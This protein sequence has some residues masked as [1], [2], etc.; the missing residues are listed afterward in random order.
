MNKIGLQDAVGAI[1]CHDITKIVPGEF[2]GRAFKKGHIITKEDM[3]ELLKLG[4][5]HIYVWQAQEG[6]VHENEAAE[7]L[8]R[9]VRG[10][11]LT[12]TEPNEG[13][14]NLVVQHDGMLEINEGLLVE[15]NMIE[16]IIVATRNNQRVVKKGDVVAGVRVIPLTI[17]ESKLQLVRDI[18]V[19]GGIVNVTP[20]K[21]LKVGIVTTGSEVFH[22]RIKDKFGPVITEKMA[23]YNCEV[24]EQIIVPDDPDR[25]SAAIKKLIANGAELIT[26]T[27]GMSVDPD[28]VTPSG[29]RNAGAQIITHGAPVLPG[30]MLLVAYL[31]DIPVL[32]LPGCVMYSKT[33]IF[34]LLIPL[35]LSGKK[36]TR[37]MVAKLGL[38]GLCMECEV[39]QFPVCPFGTGS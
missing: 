25:I 31:G 20:L 14:I 38:G 12:L 4:K 3:P 21:R 26:T 18:C 17:E 36:I 10:N 8:A 33:T 7:Q 2:K 32:G 16:N 34:D 35:V 19:N 23:K 39:C 11:G 37:A 1:L 30:S 13:K 28:D 5:E 22:G 6:F 24:L 27:G 29:I 9:I 15:I